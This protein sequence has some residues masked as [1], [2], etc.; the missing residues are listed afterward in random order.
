[1]RTGTALALGLWPIGLLLVAA[2]TKHDW[3]V[4]PSPSGYVHW[5]GTVV[6]FLSLPIGAL[7]LGR[8][9]RADA[10]WRRHAR[11]T[12]ALGV[13]SLLSFVPILA[14]VTVH[15][16]GGVPWW[17]VVPLGLVERVLA[18]T[19]I[20]AVLAVAHW[21]ITGSRSRRVAEVVGAVGRA[22]GVRA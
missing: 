16:T 1:M 4:G 2:F 17:Q 14:A 5:A 9:W 20:L 21:A 13:L 10:R 19:E 12:R 18:I 11:W 8:R 22:P 15:V 6:A 3:S 7:L